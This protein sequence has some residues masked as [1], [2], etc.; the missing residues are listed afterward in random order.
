LR[1]HIQRNWKQPKQTI[2]QKWVR[3]T[4]EDLN[5]IKGQRSRLEDRI[6]ERYGFAADHVRKEI[7]NLAPLAKLIS[8]SAGT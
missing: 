1:G 8:L 5:A 2:K 4:D 7:D 3:L 6:Y